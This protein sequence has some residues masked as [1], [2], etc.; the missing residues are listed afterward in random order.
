MS[1]TLFDPAWCE[2]A[3]PPP[4][5]RAVPVWELCDAAKVAVAGGWTE[6]EF[7]LMAAF[8][9]GAFARKEADDGRADDNR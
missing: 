9:Y 7:M 6:E 5:Q 4:A 3:G 1:A 2:T 8:A